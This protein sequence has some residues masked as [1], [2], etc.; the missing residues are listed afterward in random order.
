LFFFFFFRG[1]FILLLLL[2]CSPLEL[3]RQRNGGFFSLKRQKAWEGK[4]QAKKTPPTKQKI[5]FF[6]LLFPSILGSFFPHF[7][8]KQD[9]KNNSN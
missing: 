2:R 1:L 9:L 6:F 7:V 4:K 5:R 8:C 3:R